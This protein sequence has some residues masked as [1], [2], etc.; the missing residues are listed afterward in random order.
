MVQLVGAPRLG[1]K[2]PVTRGQLRASGL[3]LDQLGEAGPTTPGVGRLEP[4]WA[5][6][7]WTENPLFSEQ[8]SSGAARSA[9][10][11]VLGGWASTVVDGSEGAS[12][13]RLRQLRFETAEGSSGEEELEQCVWS[14]RGEMEGE[15]LGMVRKWQGEPGGKFLAW[16]QAIDTRLRQLRARSAGKRLAAGDQLGEVQAAIVPLSVGMGAHE[17]VVAV[18]K[19]QLVAAAAGQVTSPAALEV[20]DLALQLGKGARGGSGQGK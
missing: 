4:V 16:E 14:G 18:L 10:D 3:S 6:P 11:K 13:P 19:P 8:G 17:K 15:G 5:Q 7:G 9:R 2:I 12:P 1:I 20:P